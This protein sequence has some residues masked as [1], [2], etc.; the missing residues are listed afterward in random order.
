M[1]ELGAYI[2]IPFCKQKCLYCDFTSFAQREEL[3]QGYIQALKKEIINWKVQNEDAIIRTIYIGGG[4]PSY[5]DSKYIVEILNLLGKA[6]S[7]T[8]EVNPRNN[9]SRKIKTI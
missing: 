2:H 6:P 3:Q 9:Y 8:I 1:K 5:I 7:I 4:T